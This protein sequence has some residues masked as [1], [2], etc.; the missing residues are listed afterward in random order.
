MGWN[1][2]GLAGSVR[3]GTGVSW[4]TEEGKLVYPMFPPSPRENKGILMDNLCVFYGE[5]HVG[6]GKWCLYDP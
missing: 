5:F 6:G 3:D 4:S 2:L 1:G